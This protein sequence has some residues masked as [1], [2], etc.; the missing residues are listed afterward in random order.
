MGFL[1]K[2]FALRPTTARGLVGF[3]LVA[4]EEESCLDHPQ[5]YLTRLPEARKFSGV[6]KRKRFRSVI[7]PSERWSR[8]SN[9][10]SGLRNA[11]AG[12]RLLDSIGD[13]V[14]FWSRIGTDA[15]W[16]SPWRLGRCHFVF[17]VLYFFAQVLDFG[18]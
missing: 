2:K 11:D 4:P 6:R 3:S 1:R 14:E 18:L 10:K 9:C 15:A 8:W 13:T 17:E 7:T 12:K 16:W 5:A